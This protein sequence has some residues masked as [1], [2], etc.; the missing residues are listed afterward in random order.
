MRQVWFLILVGFEATFAAT[1]I[2]APPVKPSYWRET[3]FSVLFTLPPADAAKDSPR[4]VELHVS[5]DKGKTWEVAGR[6]KPTDKAIPFKAPKDG[7]YW[8]M[9]R[10]K[11]A[12]GRY[13]PSG[14]PVAE[15][16]VIVDTQPPEL[17][18]EAKHGGGG[19][20]IVRWHVVDAHLQAETF[21]LEYKLAAVSENWRHVA[22]DPADPQSPPFE[23]GGETTIVLPLAQQ[24]GELTVR[25]EVLDAAGNR[26]VKEQ[27]VAAAELQPFASPANPHTSAFPASYPTTSTP[28]WEPEDGDTPFE[29]SDNDG[30]R[31]RQAS[32]SWPAIGAV[33]RLPV[34]PDMQH[35]NQQP[36]PQLSAPLGNGGSLPPGV[37]PQMVNKK[38]LELDYDVD[39]IG[40][41]G[42]AQIELWI[43][44]DSGRTWTSYGL[45][46]DCHS[47]VQVNVEGEGV[48]GFR[49]VVE[50]T[51]GLRGPLPVAGDL[52]DLWVG[53]DLTKPDAHLISAVQGQ[54]DEADRLIISW[55]AADRSLPA[56]GV[57]LFWSQTPQGPW[58]T[59]ASGLE[60]SG[61]YAWRLD[62]RLPSQIY[63]LLE[64]RDEAGNV[65]NDALPDPISLERIHPQG[66]IRQVRPL[67]ALPRETKLR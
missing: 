54:G 48:Y 57:S 37:R 45:D 2:A 23:R 61:R 55:Q 11:Y 15:L 51:T 49:V 52:P 14:P 19:E 63:V 30:S 8:F 59:I 58:S 66:R 18:L 39:A 56:R 31:L 10:T 28:N 40:S 46:E 26:S 43:T 41:A 21:K 24:D 32:G 12:S 29:T 7:E 34:P 47:P 3:R 64:V 33:Q 42:V 44:T 22:V 65:A 6:A 27:P 67:S 53:V 25:A 50:T 17:E 62:Q 1:A 60:N 36:M 13:L 16:K 5:A 20:L 38:R 9:P 4:E 35:P